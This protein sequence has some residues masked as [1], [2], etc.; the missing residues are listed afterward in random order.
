MEENR[1]I[2]IRLENN[3]MVISSLEVAMNFGK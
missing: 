3:Q 1:E 2:K